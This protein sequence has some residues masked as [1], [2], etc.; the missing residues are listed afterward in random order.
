MPLLNEAVVIIKVLNV[1]GPSDWPA[2]LVSSAV[3]LVAAGIGA[4]AVVWTTSKS[5]RQGLD[6]DRALRA[7]REREARRSA[8]HALHAELMQI[9]L[10]RGHS[11][12][13]WIHLPMPVDAYQAARPFLS[14]LETG[15]RER[16]YK[17]ASMV[18]EYN[19]IAGYVGLIRF[20]GQVACVDYA[21]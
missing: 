14:D 10:M 3:A 12:H 20:D 7:E 4:L 8:L 19:T 9:Y 15:D 13:G 16:L 6:Y 18:A 17:A 2:L 5:R 1:E 11:T 21:A